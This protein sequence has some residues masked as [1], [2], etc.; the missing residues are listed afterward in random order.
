MCVCVCVSVW[1]RGG[2]CVFFLDG[3]GRRVFASTSS[4]ALDND[5]ID[6]HVSDWLKWLPDWFPW[7]IFATAC[8]TLVWKMSN[9][10]TEQLQLCFYDIQT[11]LFNSLDQMKKCFFKIPFLSIKLWLS[12][13]LF[14]IFHSCQWG[15]ECFYS[16]PVYRAVSPFDIPFLAV[17]LW[18]CFVFHSC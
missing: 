4:R 8:V 16:I 18:V 15:C 12:V 2:V 3:E 1:E 13:R 10:I 11:L 14:Y 5:S 17:G 7:T 6:S 9:M